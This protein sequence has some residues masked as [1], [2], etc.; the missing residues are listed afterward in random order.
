L[1]VR[2]ITL[3]QCLS[4]T[5]ALA[6]QFTPQYNHPLLATTSI[7][8]DIRAVSFQL[9]LLPP[10]SRVLALCIIC[11]GSLTS[12]HPSVL[13]EGPRPES[14]VDQEFFFSYPDLLGCGVRRAPA[15]RSLRTEA[16]KAAWE[17]GVIL[18]PSNENAASC[19]LLDLLEQ[20]SRTHLKYDMS[21]ISFFQATS[22]VRRDRGPM[23]TCHMSVPLLRF[24]T[25]R[26]LIPRLPEP[27][28]SD[29]WCVLK[30]PQVLH[31]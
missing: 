27:T 30:L 22:V 19:Y 4:L 28:G 14:L 18:Q 26:T 17:I 29:T 10:Q 21:L 11:C 5:R 23:R 3:F 31:V 1:R 15:Y 8:M 7:K 25:L 20:S 24:G 9:H 13:G 6:L 12:F 16:L 2:S